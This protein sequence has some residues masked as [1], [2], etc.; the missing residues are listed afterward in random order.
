MASRSYL[1]CCNHP[2]MINSFSWLSLGTPSQTSM[3]NWVS[4]D[5]RISH[6]KC[7]NTTPW[8]EGV[9][10]IVSLWQYSTYEVDPGIKT[11]RRARCC[12]KRY[13][14]ICPN[15]SCTT[16]YI[17]HHHRQSFY[18]VTG[19]VSVRSLY[20]RGCLVD[21]RIHSEASVMI[22]ALFMVMSRL[23]K[24]RRINWMPVMI[25]CIQLPCTL[26][27][28]FQVYLYFPFLHR[29]SAYGILCESARSL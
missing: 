18:L 9:E 5:S 27:H 15:S 4:P 10:N 19:K 13:R 8:H 22:H 7:P 24:Y 20:V 16:T 12:S 11:P 23:Y 26:H 14:W 6:I 25:W 21:C 2:W 29:V 1:I 17:W 3:F 28:T